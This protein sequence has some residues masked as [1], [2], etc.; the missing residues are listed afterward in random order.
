MASKTFLLLALAL[1]VV[2]LITSEV[3]VAKDLASNP[4]SEVHDTGRGGYY[5]GGGGGG[6][7]KGG[8]RGG[9]GK[10]GGGGGHGKGGGRGGGGGGGGGRYVRCSVGL[11]LAKI[12]REMTRVA[13]VVTFPITCRTR[14]TET[15]TGHVPRLATSVT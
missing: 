3:A 12:L 4:D 13:K 10:G 8:G 7:G 2:L 15:F 6:Y 1:A 5:N 9:Y 11:G 14:G